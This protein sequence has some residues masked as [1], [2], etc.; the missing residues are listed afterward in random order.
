MMGMFRIADDGPLRDE[1][2]DC[3]E[4]WARILEKQAGPWHVIRNQGTGGGG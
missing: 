2:G 1:Y 3:E 4:F